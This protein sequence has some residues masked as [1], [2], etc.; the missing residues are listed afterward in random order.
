MWIH[1]P[2]T[3]SLLEHLARPSHA[4][5]ALLRVD[6]PQR[7]E[8]PGVL[9]GQRRRLVE[10]VGHRV[11]LEGRAVMGHVTGGDEARRHA[12]LVH[13]SDHHVGLAERV[14]RVAPHLDGHPLRR[15]RVV[16]HL[17]AIGG[18]GVAQIVDHAGHRFT[19]PV[20]AESLGLGRRVD[21]GQIVERARSHDLGDDHHPDLRFEPALDLV[22]D[23][24]ELA[25]GHGRTRPR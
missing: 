9:R 1:R 13:A 15:D 3:H 23:R 19:R 16:P 21:L 18:E 14:G 11:V 17:L 25:T 8:S 22:L 10:A 12:E 20:V 7:R 2:A 4:R 5:H 24:L 6:R